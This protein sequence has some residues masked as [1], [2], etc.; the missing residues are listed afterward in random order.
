MEKT[1]VFISWSLGRSNYIAET[2]QWWLKQVVQTSDPWV[3]SSD[4]EA[5]TRSMKEIEASLANTKFGI[6]C[7]T[8]ENV[9]RPWLNYEAGALSKQVG[10][11]ESRVVPLLFGFEDKADIT[12][13]VGQ[14]QA[15]LANKEGFEK[16]AQALNKSIPIELQRTSE[17]VTATHDAFW[18]A[19]EKRLNEV[20]RPQKTVRPPTRPTD[21]MF[22]EIVNTVRELDSKIERI[23][24]SGQGSTL[25]GSPESRGLESV[26]FFD[27][28]RRARA[29]AKDL[30][31][32]ERIRHLVRS[33]L[34]EDLN[35][36]RVSVDVID[37]LIVI[38]TYRD[39][40][41]D[42]CGLIVQLLHSHLDSVY[43]VKFR[44]HRLTHLTED[45]AK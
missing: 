10:E 5:G 34:P 41:D 22:R 23:M 25:F 27:A 3:S 31:T 40:T 33:I 4:I 18:P 20:P 14:F 2:V 39:L 44:N 15:V 13:P 24:F 45:D 30:K 6:I 7:V 36:R 17:E 42:E 9:E 11:G 19:L 32:E 35:P 37:D 29:Q 38:G 12:T 26:E 28:Q 21:D 16:L 43:R 1:K 8:P